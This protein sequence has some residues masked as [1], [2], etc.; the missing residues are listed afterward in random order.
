MPARLEIIFRGMTASPAVEALVERWATRLDRAFDRIHRCAVTIEQPHRS[1]HQ[2]Q[3]FHVRI[4]I[5]VPDAAIVV[6]RDHGDDP[7]HEDVHVAI[8]DA[9]HAARRR[10]QDHVRIRRGEVKL[11]VS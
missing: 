11:H 2:G 6:S 8:A 1:Q 5:G 4:E 7:A 3:T 9:F 10:L